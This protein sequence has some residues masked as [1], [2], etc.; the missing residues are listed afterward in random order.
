MESK[1]KFV[2]T[3]RDCITAI[4]LIGAFTLR[5]LGINSFTETLII[6]VGLGYGILWIREREIIKLPSLKKKE[7]T[8][9]G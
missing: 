9:N 7:D 3:A 5:A 2:I 8:D 4:M 1:A 6:G